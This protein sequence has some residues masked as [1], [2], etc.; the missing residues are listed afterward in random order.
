M[1]AEYV[2]A[3]EAVKEVVWLKKFFFDPGVIRME[4]VLL[5]L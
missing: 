3:C 2:D 5:V 1:E 4:Q